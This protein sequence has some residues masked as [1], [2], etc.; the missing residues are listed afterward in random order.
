MTLTTEAPCA[1]TPTGGCNA[2]V[3]HEA[4][5]I[6]AV[7]HVQDVLINSLR[8]ETRDSWRLWRPQ[9]TCFS[10]LIVGLTAAWPL[11]AALPT[12]VS[13]VGP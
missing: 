3:T 12:R 11:T 1:N 8:D 5:T 13:Q 9:A 7:S 10:A 2:P 6:Y 4:D